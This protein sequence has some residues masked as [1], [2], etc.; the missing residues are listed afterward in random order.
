MD[1][2]YKTLVQR[3]AH[4]RV[5][6]SARADKVSIAEQLNQITKSHG[7]TLAKLRNLLDTFV[8]NQILFQLQEAVAELEVKF[9]QSISVDEIVNLTLAE[10][11]ETS[12]NETLEYIG[13]KSSKEIS[14]LDQQEEHSY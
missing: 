14:V 11:P 10:Y 9:K 8:E 13:P 3:Q 1:S 12:H 5:S 4:G 6:S 2:H 7:E